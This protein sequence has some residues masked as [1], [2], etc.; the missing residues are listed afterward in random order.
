[1]R[2]ISTCVRI[3]CPNEVEFTP[4]QAH[5]YCSTACRVAASREHKW[6]LGELRRIETELEAGTDDLELHDR[7]RLVLWHLIHYAPAL[8]SIEDLEALLP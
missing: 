1:M 5:L 6:L 3:G 8:V 7:R 4:W 2:R